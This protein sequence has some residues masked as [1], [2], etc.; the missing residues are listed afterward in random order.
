MQEFPKS[1]SLSLDCERSI[2]F[3]SKHLAS[4]R[5]CVC[6][7]REKQNLPELK[8]KAYDR[9]RITL[10]VEIDVFL[11]RPSG[12]VRRKSLKVELE[13]FSSFP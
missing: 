4:K 6:A 12:L 1:F 8:G 13:S 11:I 5:L 3:C 10:E 7:G 2:R 9:N